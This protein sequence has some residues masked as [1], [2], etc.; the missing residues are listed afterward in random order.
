MSNI[1]HFAGGSFYV[2]TSRMLT[3]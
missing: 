3:K 2:I 1:H